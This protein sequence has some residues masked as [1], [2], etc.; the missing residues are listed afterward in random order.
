MQEEVRPTNPQWVEDEFTRRTQG[1]NDL[2]FL[3]KFG[4]Y[5]ANAQLLEMGA[6]RVLVDK[7][8]EDFDEVEAMS[9]GILRKRLKSKGV[10]P[11][12]LFGLEHIT[13]SRNRIAHAILAEHHLWVTVTGNRSHNRQ[14][15]EIDKAYLELIY[16][17]IFFEFVEEHDMFLPANEGASTA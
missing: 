7:F 5:M 10:R 9:L 1:Y 14:E 3:E 16:F 11:D 13:D 6:K 2:N 4:M 15:R 8:D 12:I 17:N